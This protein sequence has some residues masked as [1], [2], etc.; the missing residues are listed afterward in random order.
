MEEISI[1]SSNTRANP[2]LDY[3]IDQSFDRVKRPFVISF[4]NSTN[5]T[6]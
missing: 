2:C 5:R 6:E 4:E 3:L 1:K